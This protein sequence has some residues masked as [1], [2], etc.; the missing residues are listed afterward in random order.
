MDLP[1]SSEDEALQEHEDFVKCVVIVTA[2]SLPYHVDRDPLFNAGRIGFIRAI[3][4]FDSVAGV[5]FKSFACSCIRWEVFDEVRRNARFGRSQVRKQR[6]LMEIREKLQQESGQ[7]VS[8]EALLDA[9]GAVGAV[10]KK[11]EVL[12]CDEPYLPLEALHN[13]PCEGVR[14]DESA[15]R[16]ELYGVLVRNVDKLKGKH[17]LFVDLHYFG[18]TTQAE[19]AEMFGVTASRICQ[20]RAEAVGR[21]RELCAEEFELKPGSNQRYAAN[22]SVVK[23]P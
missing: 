13:H 14:P 16:E 17:R 20:I 19:I 21:L 22:L 18:G 4:E 5:P 23:T 8:D 6:S 12:L 10:R 3:R 7:V 9:V 1:S 2:K 11:Y 15:E